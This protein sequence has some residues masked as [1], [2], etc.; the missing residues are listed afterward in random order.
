MTLS[1]ATGET[2]L[3]LLHETISA[4]LDATAARFPDHEA[5]VDCA[6]G[7]RWTYAAFAADVDT[8][9]RGFAGSGVVKGDRVGIWAPNGAEWT[10]VQYATAKVGAI[11]VNINPAYRTHELQYVLNQAAIKLLVAAPS[12]KTSDYAGMIEEVRDEVATLEQVVLIG[13]ES[14]DELW[15]AA[16]Q[17]SQA[18]LEAIAAGLSPD[19]PI[20]IQY[21][22]GT[23]GFPK[24]ATLSHVNILN[25]GF[26][27]GEVCRYTEADRIC[28][29]VPFYHCFGMVMGN[30]A[31]TTHG[32][33]MVIPAPGFDRVEG[34][35]RDAR[36]EGAVGDELGVAFPFQGGAADR[37]GMMRRLGLRMRP[38]VAV[39]Q[40][41]Q[42]GAVQRAVAVGGVDRLLEGDEDGG[43]GNFQRR[44]GPGVQFVDGGIALGMVRGG[45]GGRSV[46]GVA[47]H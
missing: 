8:L 25:N 40:R 5:M 12:F 43:R 34:A 14:W 36:S 18:E 35:R 44:K 38:A 20:N 13:R 37:G 45:H 29:P 22:S 4:N 3:P 23:T 46:W 47:G 42:M 31:A 2:D 28:I 30:L 21:T 41:Q 6:T 24:G 7:K 1:I 32:A 9:A 15:A 33:C 19:D 10:L 27:V 17:V 11:L 26:H 39:D 16:E